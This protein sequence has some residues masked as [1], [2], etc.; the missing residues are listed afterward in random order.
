MGPSAIY[1]G[2]H[3]HLGELARHLLFITMSNFPLMAP[4]CC[5]CCRHISFSSPTVLLQPR[6]T[7][8][9]LRPVFS[10]RLSLPRLLFPLSL[11]AFKAAL[12]TVDNGLAAA[13]YTVPPP[14]VV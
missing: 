14:C 1:I 9:P 6:Q 11:S 13:A 4:V 7:T 12:G 3:P 5:G 2:A 8:N 10:L